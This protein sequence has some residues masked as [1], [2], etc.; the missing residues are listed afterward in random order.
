MSRQTLDFLNESQLEALIRYYAQE[1]EN[2]RDLLEKAAASALT[3]PADVHRYGGGIEQLRHLTADAERQIRS[4][5]KE[6]E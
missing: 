4:L 6:R 3:A 1:I 5:Q 2:R